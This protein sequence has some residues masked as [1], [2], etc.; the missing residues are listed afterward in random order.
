MLLIFLNYYSLYLSPNIV[1][2]IVAELIAGFY[3][4]FILIG[5]HEKEI[6]F[7]QNPEMNF[8]DHQII[9]CRNYD[10]NGLFWLLIMGGMQYQTEHHLFPQIPFYRLPEAT[11]I[12]HP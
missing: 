11:K 6:K 12:I 5:N 10:Y 2:W 9:T 8:I 7:K 1:A 4:A 3:S